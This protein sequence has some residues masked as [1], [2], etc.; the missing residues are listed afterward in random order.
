MLGFPTGSSRPH[1]SHNSLAFHFPK[2][3]IV[4]SPLLHDIAFGLDVTLPTEM[5]VRSKKD[6]SVRLARSP[7]KRVLAFVATSSPMT[8]NAIALCSGEQ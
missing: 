8:F 5:L 4:R 2:A 3:A 6:R 7:H 1:F